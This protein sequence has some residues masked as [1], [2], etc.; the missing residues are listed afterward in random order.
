MA[1]VYINTR[2]VTSTSTRESAG[3]AAI[4]ASD[5]ICALSTVVTWGFLRRT[6]IDVFTVFTIA[7]EA[8][9]TGTFKDDNSL[10]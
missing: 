5:G 3:A 1:L 9:I 2:I 6:F 4:E 8:I 10:I 7:S